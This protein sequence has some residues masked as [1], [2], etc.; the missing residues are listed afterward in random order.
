MKNLIIAILIIIILIGGGAYLYINYYQEKD[1]GEGGLNIP[2][3]EKKP[4]NIGKNDGQN[5]SN[6]KNSNLDNLEKFNI[7]GDCKD[8]CDNNCN[9]EQENCVDD[10]QNDYDE[11]YTAANELLAMCNYNCQFIPVPPGPAQCLNLCK[12]DF[13]K[14]T[15]KIDLNEC[16]SDCNDKENICLEDCYSDC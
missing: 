9:I 11:I 14:N 15:Y 12:E 3:I 8:Q 4:L 13:E 1:S 5:L 10:C 2:S 7:D 6:K 16:K